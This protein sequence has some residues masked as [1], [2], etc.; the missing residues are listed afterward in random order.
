R[1]SSAIFVA[2]ALVA[3]LFVPTASASPAV[4]Y[5][6]TVGGTGNEGGRIIGVDGS[7]NVYQFGI[8][9][10]YT[11]GAFLAKR[12]P[13][14]DVLW[15]RVLAFGV[16]WAW[17]ANGAAVSSDAAIGSNCTAI[18][19]AARI[20]DGRLHDKFVVFVNFGTLLSER[21][22]DQPNDAYRWSGSLG[23]YGDPYY[24]GF[25]YRN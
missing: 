12:N 21:R 4:Q 25:S 5:G 14:G 9:S 6:H 10:A 16:A 17:L 15:Q 11:A 22:L 18:V 20:V 23:P 1:S 3:F 2:A 24:L 7:G 13:Q 19:V 8:T